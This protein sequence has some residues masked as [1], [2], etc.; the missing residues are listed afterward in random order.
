[1]P[2]S[3][4]R[5]LREAAEERHPDLPT[6]ELWRLGRRA[7]RRRRTLVVGIAVAASISV[8]LG[9][10]GYLGALEAADPSRTG[11]ATVPTSPTPDSNTPGSPTPEPSITSE[12]NSG[13]D[14]P[15]TRDTVEGDCGVGERPAYFVPGGDP[16]VVIGCAILGRSGKTVEFS[17]DDESIGGKDHICINPAFAGRG[18]RGFYIP[19]ACL[20]EPVRHR[21]DVVDVLV[22]RQGVR[23]YKRV[24]WGTTGTDSKVVAQ[25]GDEQVQA[26]IFAVDPSVTGEV[27]AERLFSVF[28]V[29]LPIGTYCI[30]VTISTAEAPDETERVEGRPQ[31]C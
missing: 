31:I 27:T 1:M 22:P 28:V 15:S 21:L 19:G 7:R 25:Y 23:G 11:V 3:V 12:P 30:D 8:A 29:E 6:S 26:A 18:H 2:D 5:L 9:T 14:L 10:A 13:S 4:T 20:R 16:A 24:L 17:V